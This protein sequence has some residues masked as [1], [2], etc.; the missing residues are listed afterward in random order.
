MIVKF[1]SFSSRTIGLLAGDA[2]ALAI[3]TLYGFETHG[4]LETA[5]V[6]IA[7]TYL[8]LLISWILIAPHLGAFDPGRVADIKQLWRPFWAMLLAAPL[9]AWMR[10]VW[11]GR[12]ILP[13][14]VVILGGISAL[15]ILVWR[16]LY[17]LVIVK[18]RPSW[19]KQT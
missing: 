6:R 3:T 5:G 9:A 12:P 19:M 17:L 13:I 15:A 7:V 16:A 1:N 14:F 2:L 8:P 11:L 4:T 10:G 18:F